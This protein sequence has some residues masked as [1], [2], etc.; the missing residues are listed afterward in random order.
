MNSPRSCSPRPSAWKALWQV[1][2]RGLRP[3]KPS[4]RSLLHPYRFIPWLAVV[5][6]VMLAL[7][8]PVF[9]GLTFARNLDQ[10][11]DVSAAI[12]LALSQA[13]TTSHQRRFLQAWVEV[14]PASGR[15]PSEDVDVS[16][17]QEL[18]LPLAIDAPPQITQALH[19]V[20]DEHQ[21][22]S[23]D[24]DCRRCVV[25]TWKNL[26]EG[27]S[28][29]A[30]VRPASLASM[31]GPHA[32]PVDAPRL[33]HLVEALV[34]QAVNR[35]PAPPPIIL[36]PD[37]Q[38]NAVKEGLLLSI[39]FGAHLVVMAVLW[40]LAVGAGAVV[41][42]IWDRRR[43]HGELEVLVGAYHPPWVSYLGL[44]ARQLPKLLLVYVAMLIVLL[45]FR[46]PVHW[47]FLLAMFPTIVSV[48]VLSGLWSVFLTSLFHHPKGRNV[49]QVLLS[50]LTL[51]FIWA[52]RVLLVF[53]ALKAYQPLRFIEG[54]ESLLN[55]WHWW[56][57]PPPGLWLASVGLWALIEWRMGPRREGLR[58][59]KRS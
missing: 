32:P 22:E 20:M 9:S 51:T 29:S 2:T 35:L 11:S 31:D 17:L 24:L 49:A 4:D 54:F 26:R 37:G 6:A 7:L 41:G 1:S 12:E 28:W 21:I 13:D 19:E 44:I 38:V 55:A 18:M 33:S 25:V 30:L 58:E 27:P 16:L 8:Y 46:L 45:V 43:T 39:R 59:A 53:G 3:L 40:F 34:R 52:S 10:A 14:A 56:W 15:E 57:V 50:P 42:S 23:A 48:F 47:P 5:V 36:A